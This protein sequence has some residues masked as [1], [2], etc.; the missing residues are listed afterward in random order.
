M[1]RGVY[2]VLIQLRQKHS[3]RLRSGLCWNL[4]EGHYIYTGSAMGSGSMSLEK[5]LERHLKVG[6][7]CFW[8]IDRL[9]NGCA[10]VL[11]TIYAKTADRMECKVNQKI[12]SLPYASPIKGFGSSDC[13][14]G[15]IG[16]LIFLNSNPDHLIK[17]LRKAYYD[18]ELN[19]EEMGIGLGYR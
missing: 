16:H 2:S 1:S 12:S 7:R 5:R 17:L 19:Y 3:I 18:L 15:C 6:K 13:R 4:Q 11:C 14:S 8:H 9:L 10:K